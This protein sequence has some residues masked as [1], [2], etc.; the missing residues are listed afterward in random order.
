MNA[1]T[2]LGGMS[3][4]DES[5]RVRRLASPR[6]HRRFGARLQ[7]YVESVVPIPA[8]R[9]SRFLFLSPSLN[10]QKRIRIKST[11]RIRQLLEHIR[12]LVGRGRP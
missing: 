6:P 12:Q 10:L 7:E 5:N 1:W 9:R 8:F 11:E 2:I 4:N 3:T